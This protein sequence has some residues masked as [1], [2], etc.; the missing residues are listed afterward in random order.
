MT[1]ALMKMLESLSGSPSL[2]LYPPLHEA[3][4]EALASQD[5]SDART[6]LV[7][8]V[9]TANSEVLAAL[10]EGAAVEVVAGRRALFP[11]SA[12]LLS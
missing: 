3:M 2:P 4:P 12:N 8:A 6:P 10:D 1:P 5:L 7:P 11:R 9:G